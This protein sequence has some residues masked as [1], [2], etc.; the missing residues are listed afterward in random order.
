MLRRLCK[1]RFSGGVL[2]RLCLQPG[3]LCF[4]TFCAVR[5]LAQGIFIGEEWLLKFHGALC[6]R[7]RLIFAAT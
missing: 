2:A 1:G 5:C 3:Q 7:I 4:G 6:Q